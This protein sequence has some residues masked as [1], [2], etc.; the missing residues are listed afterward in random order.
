MSSPLRVK[1]VGRLYA[2]QTKFPDGCW[3]TIL[4]LYGSRAIAEEAKTELERRKR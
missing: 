3:R 1:R 4:G 2:V